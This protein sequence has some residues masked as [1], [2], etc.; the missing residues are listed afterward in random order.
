MGCDPK[1]NIVRPSNESERRNQVSSGELVENQDQRCHGNT[2][3][4]GGGLV[5]QI[6]VGVTF[7][8][9]DRRFMLASG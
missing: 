4:A 9:L 5:L 7:M 6:K 1:H 3:T 2:E 8:R